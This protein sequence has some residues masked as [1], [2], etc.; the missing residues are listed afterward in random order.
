MLLRA[1]VLLLLSK[2]DETL[3]T[4]KNLHSGNK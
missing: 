4:L 1:H 2:N 3:K